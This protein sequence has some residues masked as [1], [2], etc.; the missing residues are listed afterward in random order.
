MQAVE[1][2]ALSAEDLANE[3]EEARRELFDLRFQMSLGRLPNT[4]RIAE[5]KRDIARYE[6]VRR[7]RELW[8]AYE[9]AGGAAAGQKE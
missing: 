7:E 2:R 8:A 1:I 6:T 3:L 5:V 4:N 9:A